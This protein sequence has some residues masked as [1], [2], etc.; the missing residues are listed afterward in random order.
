MNPAPNRFVYAWRHPPALGVAGR[1][2]GRT[3]VPVD[4]RRAKR[5]AHR[6]RRHARREGLPRLIV[7]S[8]Q[9]R[10]ADVGR[11]LAAW[12]WCHRIDERLAELDFG[13]WEGRSWQAIGA[14]PIGAWCA[15]FVDSAPGDGESLRALI[16]RCRAFID[17][18][19]ATPTSC[20]IVGHAGWIN[21]ARWLAG[22]SAQPPTAADWPAAP[23]HASLTMLAF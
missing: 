10:C 7:T 22:Q 20:C 16:A 4:P 6:I 14:T 23:A 3:D 17:D 2:I 15:D 8:P 19:A 1:C 13:D 9:R 5:L 21:A 18:D 11:W 12:G